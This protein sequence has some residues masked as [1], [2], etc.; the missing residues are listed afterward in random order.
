MLCNLYVLCVPFVAS[1]GVATISLLQPG[2][3]PNSRYSDQ[4]SVSTVITKPANQQATGGIAPPF[5]GF[6]PF[7]IRNPPL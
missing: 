1:I 2:C 7:T 6:D 3:K 4:Q 5:P